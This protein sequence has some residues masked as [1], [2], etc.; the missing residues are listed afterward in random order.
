MTRRGWLAASLSLVSFDSCRLL[1]GCLLVDICVNCSTQFSLATELLT[2][3][4]TV[5]CEKY[6][7][8]KTNNVST[9]GYTGAY[10]DF[11]GV[12]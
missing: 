9:L 2:N 12:G 7:S 10:Q 8:A 5:S 3:L 6:V 4:T 11:V 1:I